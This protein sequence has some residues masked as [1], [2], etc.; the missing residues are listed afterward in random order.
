MP[1]FRQW[2]D[3]NRGDVRATSLI[4]DSFGPGTFGIDALVRN[5]DRSIR[6]KAIRALVRGDAGGG[7]LDPAKRAL[8]EPGGQSGVD[9]P[10]I[11]DD[12]QMVRGDE[13]RRTSVECATNET[14]VV[15]KVDV[16][17]MH[18]RQNARIGPRPAEVE[19]QI[20]AIE[21]LGKQPR[22]EPPGPF[23]EITEQQARTNVATIDE[24]I[25]GQ[26]LTGLAA[27]LE[28]GS[29][30]VDIVDVERLPAA[31]IDIDP[32]AATLL[33]TCDADIVIAGKSDRVTTDDD[34]AVG[35]AAELTV[36]PQPKVH[37]ELSCDE[38]GLVVLVLAA[39][40]ADNLLQCDQ[41]GVELAQDRDDS[42]G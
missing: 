38:V 33:A 23:I 8:P 41:I 6:I 7:P 19:S 14:K 1:T 9:E 18:K 42:V 37:T 3:Q 25:L 26:Q 12:R 35:R 21:M 16:V 17:E 34:I 28:E 15:V 29:S 22:S 2:S 10:E 36:L 30:K 40:N 27:T 39:L 11:G 32:Q 5:Y 20:S 4:L 24:N 31:Q 13:S